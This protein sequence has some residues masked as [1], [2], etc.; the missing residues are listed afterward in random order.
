MTM[1]Y[2]RSPAVEAFHVDDECI[3]LNTEKYTVT[4]LNEVGQYCWEMLEEARTV[5]A[6]AAE[7]GRQYE[8]TEEDALSDI[9]HFVEKLLLIGLIEH[10]S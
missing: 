10:A 1:R 5:S 8:I 9:H 6:L 3:L 4:K 2:K 7:V